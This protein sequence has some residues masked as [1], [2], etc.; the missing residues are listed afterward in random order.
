MKTLLFVLI[1]LPTLLPAAVVT[2]INDAGSGTLREAVANAV[3]GE[4]ITFDFATYTGSN[5]PTVSLHT[6]EIAIT[7]KNLIIDGTT[8]G[9]VVTITGNNTSRIFNLNNSDT[10]FRGIVFTEGTDTDKGGAVYQS[11]SSPEY[12]NCS[13]IDNSAPRGGA[14]YSYYSG[15]KFT[16][17]RFSENNA[18]LNGGAVYNSLSSTDFLDSVFEGNTSARGGAVYN[19]E[20]FNMEFAGCSFSKNV[21]SISGGAIGSD[22]SSETYTDCRFKD[23]EAATGGSIFTNLTSTQVIGSIFRG[24][25]AQDFGGAI[26]AESGT[27]NL[28]SSSFQGAQVFNEGGAVSLK[29]T[30]GT[31]DSCFFLSNR[32]FSKG[33]ALYLENSSPKLRNCTFQG[34]HAS[35]NGGAFFSEDSAPELFNCLIWQNAAL[36]NPTTMS[37]S[38]EKSGTGSP[39]FTQSLVENWSAG[40]L[41]GLGNLD[42]TLPANDP[43]FITP[44]T[45]L[46][47]PL[48][49]GGDLRL[50]ANSPMIDAGLSSE[51]LSADD[52][53]G[54][55]RIVTTVDL[56]AFEFQG[57]VYVNAAVV[58]GTGDGSSWAN[59]YSKLQDA[60]SQTPEGHRI[61]V[62]EGTY[63]P[64]E[65]SSTDSDLRTASFALQGQLLIRG[66]FPAEG[67][68]TL[69]ERNPKI[70]R[71]VLSGDIDQNDHSSGDNSGNAYHVIVAP[72]SLP[73]DHLDGV[74]I[75][76][77][78][79][80]E[81]DEE[82]D[83]NYIGSAAV[84]Y[85][86]LI[87][88]DDASSGRDGGGVFLV[89]DNTLSLTDCVLQG[90][91]SGSFGGAI[92]VSRSDIYLEGSRI[93][94]NTARWGGAFFERYGSSL[95]LNCQFQGNSVPETG[96]AY[97]NA[98]S[99]SRFFNCLFLSNH[100][101]GTISGYTGQAEFVN[102]TWQGN[103]AEHSN[104]IQSG[105]SSLQNCLVWGNAG[106][107]NQNHQYASLPYNSGISVTYS[108][109]QYWNT[110]DLGSPNNRDGT[111]LSLDPRFLIPLNKNDAPSLDHGDAGLRASSPVLDV[112]D[113]SANPF[114]TDLAGDPRK[115]GTID[116]GAYEGVVTDVARLWF[117]DDDGDGNLYGVEVAL[118]TDPDLADAGDPRNLRI[119]QL[120]NG[121]PKLE[122]GFNYDAPVG[123][124]WRLTRST[125]LNN[126]FEEIYRADHT[127]S[128]TN[129]NLD[130]NI[131]TKFEIE[132]LDPPAPKAFYR[133][134]AL[135]LP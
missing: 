54:N 127:S 56:G 135:Y 80:N 7:G 130:V 128:E 89:G 10:V 18:T 2:S 26:R 62:A 100:G 121:H 38:F 90:N 82:G 131:N 40:N 91:H 37:A 125:T 86:A 59:A 95:I 44:L 85:S 65:T 99:S 107:N 93:L 124:I 41:G 3:D 49:I 15:G 114:S 115:V 25:S 104:V 63:Y 58:G 113:N 6:G 27:L 32:S 126:D 105:V 21:A 123:T 134:E 66:G 88:V 46:I 87:A 81:D 1:S 111:D 116:I 39:A 28:T 103:Q 47:A 69:A 112:G 42:G 43:L 122:F 92:A 52:V 50:A 14:V 97:Y 22:R 79:A 96:S 77:G 108:L 20:A 57:P 55:A 16:S 23:N 109:I 68:P 98:F 35:Q 102:C 73:L 72:D 36:E 4:T 64:D 120:S 48:K 132:D 60:L 101:A 5:A 31:F 129:G 133:F 12:E 83:E 94:G 74:V 51:A 34:N 67:N 8:S 78:H 70:Y 29:A 30:G 106:F 13:F 118:G 19:D 61:Y 9:S 11:S 117:T 75:E 110:T 45:P 76:G 17:C 33:G 119:T 84:L 53:M 24:D 71:T